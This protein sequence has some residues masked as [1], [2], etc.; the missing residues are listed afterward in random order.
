MPS[1]MK[2]G[3][4]VRNVLDYYFSHRNRSYLSFYFGETIFANAI[5]VRASASKHR[6]DEAQ[7]R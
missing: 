2:Y 6:F 1:Q 5:G 7:N 4:R 3:R